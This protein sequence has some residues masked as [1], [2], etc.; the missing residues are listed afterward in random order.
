MAKKKAEESIRVLEINSHVDGGY[1]IKM[2]QFEK[3]AIPVLVGLLEKAKF[4]LL[5]R[6]FDEDGE[7]EEISPR[8]SMTN[9][10]EA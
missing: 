7:A 1:E 3:G 6:D 2:A 4:D 9:K 5:A 10:Y 8:V